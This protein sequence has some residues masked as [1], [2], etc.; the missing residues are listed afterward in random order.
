MKSTRVLNYFSNHPLIHKKNL[1][2]N[3]F[4]RAVRLSDSEYNDVCYQQIE[5]LLIVNGYP[6][7]FIRAVRL[8]YQRKNIQ[9]RGRIATVPNTNPKNIKLYRSL[10]YYY[11]AGLSEVIKKI[12]G[13][14]GENIIISY[15]LRTTLSYVY[16]NKTPTPYLNNSNLIYKIN[17]RDYH[18]CYVGMTCQYLARRISQHN[19]NVGREK[20]TFSPGRKCP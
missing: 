9:Y 19:Y 12:I 16:Y 17:C 18:Q 3:I 11:I 1:I 13:K 15:R 4:L 7:H 2:Y 14:I 10:T 6:R 5:K 20:K 8:F